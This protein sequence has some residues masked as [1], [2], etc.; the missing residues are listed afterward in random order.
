MLVVVAVLR[1]RKCLLKV[2]RAA[3]V[4]ARL[5]GEA[6]RRYLSMSGDNLFQSDNEIPEEVDLE[7]ITEMEGGRRFAAVNNE[8]KPGELPPVCP[9]MQELT[10]RAPVGLTR[11]M[12]RFMKY[13]VDRVHEEFP[14]VVG[15]WSEPSM[16]C[17]RKYLARIMREPREYYVRARVG[18]KHQM[19][20][21]YKN[22]MH[23]HQIAAC[24]DHIVT[25]AHAG[26]TAQHVEKEVRRELKPNWLMR[27]LGLSECPGGGGVR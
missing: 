13:W 5:R 11:R 21:M 4:T 23:G 9:S 26:T 2:W 27:V 16:A 20:K 14:R 24:V 3:R 7:G 18:D 15:D 19:V 1:T 25:L 17:T 12:R 8:G 10:A 22:G 6:E